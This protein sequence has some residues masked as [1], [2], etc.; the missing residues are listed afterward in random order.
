M[1]IHHDHSLLLVGKLDFDKNIVH[2]EG[3]KIR[4]LL[5]LLVLTCPLV[6]MS[7]AAAVLSPIC[8]YNCVTPQHFVSM[9]LNSANFIFGSRS[10]FPFLLYFLHLMFM[11]Q[12]PFCLN[13]AGVNP[14]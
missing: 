8:G 12:F 10:L 1:N 2:E 13:L 11:G 3:R 6:L 9:F 7:K 4:F 14:Q 5:T